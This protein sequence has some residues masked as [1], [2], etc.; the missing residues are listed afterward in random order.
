MQ[1]AFA[2]DPEYFLKVHFES[3]ILINNPNMQVPCREGKNAKRPR[4]FW[5]FM[6]PTQGSL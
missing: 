3:L 4:Y 5:F 6:P 1:A 2:A